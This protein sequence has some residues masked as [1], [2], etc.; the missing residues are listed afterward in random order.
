MGPVSDER[1]RFRVSGIQ[2]AAGSAAAATAAFAA[3]SL[4]LAGTIVGAALVS[5][6]FTV[7]AAVYDHSLRRAHERLR[8][9]RTLE[10]GGRV[11]GA[12]AEPTVGPAK[13]ETAEGDGP[14][15]VLP[16]LDL[17]SVDGYHWRRIAVVS[18]LVFALAMAAVTA[19]ELV[20]GR[21]I[22]SLFTGDDASGTTIGNVVDG[23]RRQP[24]PSP[25]ETSPAPD[26]SQT[27]TVT[28]TV[29]PPPTPTVTVTDTATPTVTPTRTGSPTPTATT[30]PS[31]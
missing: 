9:V 21:P 10:T 8:E 5:A 12:R 7:L 16:A 20:T 6:T 15:L 28:E 22:S 3:S 18:L 25:T 29:T 14:T 17:E 31:G 19:F 26:G 13:G 1:T 11:A 23:P 27:P 4:G 24:D 2:V 30:S